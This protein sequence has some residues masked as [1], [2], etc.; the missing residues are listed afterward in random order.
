MVVAA[1]DGVMPQTREHAAVLAALGVSTGVVAVTKSDLADPG[2]AVAEAAA[3][4]PGAEVV[5]VSARTG[6]GLEELRAALERAAA[7]V[8]GRAKADG[9]ALR[10]LH[11]D[12]SF[13]IRGAGTV[14]TGTLW[15]GTAARGDEV[16]ILPSGRA[17]GCAR[18]R[19]TTSRSSALRPGSA[20]RS[21][22]QGW[23]ATRWRAAT[24]SWPARALPPR[25]SGSTSRS[26]GR[27]LTRA[28]TA[29]PASPSTTAHARPPPAWPS[30]AAA[31]SS[32]AS[33]S[34][35]SRRPAT[36]WSSARSHRPTPWAAGS[37]STRHHLATAPRATCS[38]ASSGAPAA[39][40]NRRPRPPRG[41][42]RLSPARNRPRSAPPRSGP[43]RP[44]APRATSRRSTPTWV[45]SA[46]TSR[47]CAR[48]GASSASAARC[49]HPTPG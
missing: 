33:S 36:A 20:S 8:P 10:R 19:S 44:C 39:R 16:Q 2:R 4:L 47:R 49:I 32:C 29:A 11:V 6:D 12:R 13:T 7:N 43:R 27:R 14:V 48:T 23:P 37:S 21:T 38:P 30:S 28:L 5:V 25:P 22:S 24:W 41:P 45:R 15:S 3:L 31:S 42:R 1:D 9:T 18:S 34:R 26:S 40:T 17:R 46:P 35:S